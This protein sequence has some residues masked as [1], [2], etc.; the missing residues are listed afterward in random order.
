M[1]FQH[2]AKC[3]RLSAGTA[4]TTSRLRATARGVST[5]AKGVMEM[6]MANSDTAVPASSLTKMG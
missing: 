1:K 5:D 3:R 2:A 4:C 6:K